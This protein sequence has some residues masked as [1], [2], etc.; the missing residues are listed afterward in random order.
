[1]RTV[2]GSVENL[3]GKFFAKDAEG[4]VVELKTGDEITQDMIV[5]GDENNPASATMKIAMI[6][7]REDMI[8]EANNEESFDEDLELELG[9]EE[10][11]ISE[12]DDEVFDEETESGDEKAK[13]SEGGSDQFA[14]RDGNAVDVNSG[15]RNAKF[16]LTSHTFEIKD[17]F[18]TES[19]LGLNPIA[20]DPYVPSTPN[21]HTP[22]T[23]PPPIAP[24]PVT[25]PPSTKPPLSG[26]LRIDGDA[27]VN[28]G[29]IATYKLTID[30]APL[31]DMKISV[32][33]S[34]IDTDSGD[35]TTETRSLTILGG[36]TSVSFTVTNN[37]D[38][39]VEQD[40]DYLVSISSYETGGLGEVTL[41][42]ASVT[43]T[44]LDDVPTLSI[45]DMTVNEA[46]G[47][48][49]FTV[50]LSDSIDEN[51]TF[52]Y[53]TSDKNPIDAQSGKDY[54]LVNN[55]GTIIAG[56]TTTTITVPIIDDYFKESDEEF[57]VNLTNPSSNA[58]IEDGEG[59][60]TI[61]DTANEVN[62][63]QDI[64]TVHV[65]LN[66]DVTAKE[67]AGEKLTH[68]FTIVDKDG[69]TVNLANGE[70]IDVTLTYSGIASVDGVEDADLTTKT[71][72][73][74]ITG[75]GGSSYTFENIVAEDYFS[76]GVEGYTVSIGSITASNTGFENIAIDTANNTSTG[77]I[78]DDADDKVVDQD[79]D[80]VY[81]Q[82]N[83]D[84][85]AKEGAG[86][87]LTHTFTIVD[88]DG[89]SV[90]LVN[91]ETIDVTLTY[92]GIDS[93]DGI[94]AADL[95]TKTTTFTITGNGGS[96]YTFDNIV[97]EDY[98]SEGVEGY[99]VSID[100]ITA[101]N[102]GFENIAIDTANNTSTGKITDDADDKVVDQDVDTLYIKI[103]HNNSVVEGS[104]LTHTVTLVDKDGV[105]VVVPAD[106]S[107]VVNLKYSSTNG[108]DDSDF[109]TII[110]QVT[111]TNGSSTTFENL[112]KDDF[113]NEG[114]E[115]YTVEVDSIVDTN[116]YYEN[117]DKY[118][119]KTGVD[120]DS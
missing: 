73:F 72:T 65:Q 2:I 1:M 64:D 82:L 12:E 88:K 61:L 109:T 19:E 59:V 58:T 63:T 22:P 120:A 80:T 67:G 37:S 112:T 83:G 25:P 44:I 76:E 24:P 10:E 94:E 28:E 49:T 5:F 41:A 79:V 117:L 118:S 52:N 34:H 53:A 11:K 8:I 27:T 71:T 30:E 45:N 92:S 87:K 99:T 86:E 54:T 119:N 85:T 81:V 40:E 36:Q 26:V 6:G 14:A 46:D 23:T 60:G 100:S 29:N 21:I 93:V 32:T 62:T 50:T 115:N 113:A 33:I 17:Q 20:R 84:V 104:K 18:E 116:N 108:V 78:T 107:I 68:T 55:Q 43:T 7:D 98:F 15:L 77:K 114:V 13:D 102:T 69:S 74:T 66:G 39:K 105:E 106:K 110:K 38:N 4:N 70:T 31:V 95:T 91:G 111:I 51:V 103:T 90:N 9:G 96:T 57:L 42:N 35:I 48:M 47:T 89:S 75:N 16:K 56:Q 3:D 97:A 101:S